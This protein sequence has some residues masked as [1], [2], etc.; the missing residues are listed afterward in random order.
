MESGDCLAAAVLVG[1]PPGEEGPSM[2]SLVVFRPLPLRSSQLDFSFT[3]LSF[4]RRAVSSL[5][6]TTFVGDFVEDLVGLFVGDALDVDL[7][8]DEGVLLEVA[9]VLNAG[10]D[11]R[12]IASLEIPVGTFPSHSEGS[13]FLVFCGMPL[14]PVVVRGGSFLPLK[15]GAVFFPGGAMLVSVK[16]P[17]KSSG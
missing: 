4:A 6:G 15:A 2:E 7:V 10:T 16:L 11:L 5:N 3:S 13:V 8:G 9:A 17:S 12:L 14:R 1:M